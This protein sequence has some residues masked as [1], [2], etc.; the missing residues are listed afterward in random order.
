MKSTPKVDKIVSKMWKRQQP[1][2]ETPPI[3]DNTRVLTIED[4]STEDSPGQ[5]AKKIEV[6]N[7]ES[8]DEQTR[9]ETNIRND[10]ANET[11]TGRYTK[12]GG[13]ARTGNNIAGKKIYLRSTRK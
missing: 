6:I 12:Y 2:E 4:T 1:V 8:T 3:Q 13:R 9:A 11:E 10:Q 5:P 7:L